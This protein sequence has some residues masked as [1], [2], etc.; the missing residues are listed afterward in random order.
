MKTLT[1]RKILL[2]SL[3]PILFLAN[4][5]FHQKQTA[6]N[7][8]T[9]TAVGDFA[10]TTN[11]SSVL[12]TIAASGA[13]FHLAL[14]DLSYGAI[15][16]ESA[17]CDYVKSHVG[18]QFPFELIAG[19]HDSGQIAGEGNINNF[20]PCLPDRLG[21]ITGTYGKEYY[22]DYPASAPLA[23]FIL[24]SPKINFISEGYYSYVNG[25]AHYLWVSNAIDSARAAGI[26]WVIVGMHKFCIGVAGHTCDVE[27]ALYNMLFSKKVDLILQ[28]HNHNYQRSKQL[29]LSSTCT[30]LASGT[31][32]AS[33]IVDDGSDDQYSKDN[34]SV[35]LIA[36]MG[37][38]TLY[39]INNTDPDYGYFA[40]LM[41]A[42]A[43]PTYG[44]V[45][46]TLSSTQ[47][48]SEFLRASGGDFHDTFSI[49]KPP[50][51]AAIVTDT[52]SRTVTGGWGSAEIGGPYS[53]TSTA[54]Y[55]VNGSE[56][57]M[58]ISTAGLQRKATLSGVNLR[59]VDMKI[60]VKVDKVAAGAGHQISLLMRQL[61]N[62]G[63]YRARLE[64]TPTGTAKLVGQKYLNSTNVTT[65]IGS[66]ITV[67]GLT[68]SANQYIW[69]RVQVVGTNPTTI[70]IKAWL[71]GQPEP[72][73]WQYT[74]SDSEAALQT[75]GNVA[76]LSRLPSTSTVAPVIFT[77]DDF[78]VMAP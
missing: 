74:G 22:F 35:I 55:S 14:G 31:F 6:A 49:T 66:G 25:S 26:P 33:C 23:R 24:I 41:A 70:R 12:D 2:L 53:G 38:Q 65:N 37:G 73:T 47:L 29:T 28:A 51:N 61:T 56:G 21:T 39:N 68:Y 43:N 34:G 30:S 15:R 20:T 32:N 9:F 13:S 62:I 8:I 40:K 10:A 52:F 59:D 64:L 16:P 18:S 44:V 71:D 27:P 75:A 42:N 36:G 50:S 54:D 78:S 76:I 46:F 17:W 63:Q 67:P 57:I 11:T 45:R 7:T 5:L 72:S 4:P 3:L 77:Y 19:N 1:V 48:T 69:L 60:R 58:K